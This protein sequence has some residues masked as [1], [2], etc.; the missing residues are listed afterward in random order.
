MEHIPSAPVPEQGSTVV[1]GQNMGNTAPPVII[2]VPTPAPVKQK[3]PYEQRFPKN[4]MLTLS[5]IQLAMAALSIITTV[6]G[7]SERYPQAHYVGAGIWCGILFGLSGIFGTISSLKPSFGMIVTF[8]VFAIISSVFCLP[9]LVI[10]SMSTAFSRCWGHSCHGREIRNAMFATQIVISL[11]QV[12]AAI[13]S[14][15]MTCKAIC[16]CC[17]PK[18]ESGVVYY[19]GG[20]AAA[21]VPN[22]LISQPIVLPQ[23]H[24]GYI[25]IP[26]SQIH[27]AAAAGATA[28]PRENLVPVSTTVDTESPPP[29]YESVAKC[30]KLDRFDSVDLKNDDTEETGGSKYQRFE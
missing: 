19:N 4:L 24:P 13:T 27:A 28:I 14:S 16:S 9:L 25:T 7:L 26:I 18:R 12:I 15:V 8:M 30:E 11:V 10:S 5:G 6:I 22:N 17:R 23:Q 1:S 3:I 21:A 20:S 2:M 29:K